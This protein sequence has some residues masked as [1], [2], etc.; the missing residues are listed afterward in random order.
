MKKMIYIAA[1]ILLVL[2]LVAVGAVWFFF[3]P[4]PEAPPGT[5]TPEVKAVT[6]YDAQGNVLVT[7]ETGTEIYELENWA[8]LEMVLTETVEIIARQKD[9]SEGEARQR[10][11]T[12]GYR[13]YTAFDATAFGALKTVKERWGMTCNTA[14]AITDLKGSLLAV[15]STDLKEKQINY[16][17]ERR[18]PYSSF[19]ALS[20]YTPALEKGI[21]SWSSMY[22]DS[23]YK[24]LKN[25]D[26]KLQDWPANASGTYSGES[27]PVYEALRKS[28]NTVAVKCLKDVGITDSMT[29]LQDKLGIS[30]TEETYVVKNYGEEEVIG[31]IALGYLETGI[32]PVEMAGYYQMFANGGSYSVPKTVREIRL[33]DGAPWYTRQA[34]AEQVISPGTA[35]TMNKLLQG[36]VADGGTGES[37]RCGDIA[38]AG[39]T[40]TGDDYADNWFV[41]VT[42]GYS[43]AVWHGQHESN[44]ADQMF[45]MVIRELYSQLPDANRTF[46]THHNLHQIAYCVHSGKAFSAGCTQ[47]E[48]G[49]FANKDTLPVCDTCGKS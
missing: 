11:F 34:E 16:A 45:A 41:G 10:L 7:T 4:S 6:L 36:V 47:I 32:T 38:V 43:L 24:Q 5:D 2:V 13:I 14:C 40:G 49:Y 8:Y 31:N 26:G 9:C 19:K 46:V 12:E 48:V 18:S 25:E 20:V 39:K 42:P 28:L 27:L 3:R 30:L 29:F 17:I 35:D 37:A 15:Y 44:Q 23:P 33:E 1:A 22:M 21:A